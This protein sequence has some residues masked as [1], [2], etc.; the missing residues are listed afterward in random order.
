MNNITS[1]QFE[2]PEYQDSNELQNPDGGT[3]EK[4]REVAKDPKEEPAHDPDEVQVLLRGG[5][6]PEEA[7]D[8]SKRASSGKS[9]PQ[10]QY[11][12]ETIDAVN[13]EIKQRRR[14][15]EYMDQ[16]IKQAEG[17]EGY[18]EPEI[19]EAR[20]NLTEYT[21][22]QI[23]EETEAMEKI[24]K[25]LEKEVAYGNKQKKNT[26]KLLNTSEIAQLRQGGFTEAD[27]K[28]MQE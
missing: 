12:D 9:L 10:K 1:E 28:R 26:K 3:G 8:L 27:I 20:K 14:E 25:S 11:D 23:S 21:E 5:Y 4:I 18:S 6:T 17:D 15:R 24:E 7:I 13:R 2:E 16:E 19:N 22:K